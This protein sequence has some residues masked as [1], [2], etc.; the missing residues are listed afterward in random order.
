MA[1]N[2]MDLGSGLLL[3]AIGTGVSLQALDYGLGSLRNIG[4]G[5]FPMAAGVAL[6]VLGLALAATSLRQTPEPDC[7]PTRKRWLPALC[8]IG[9]LLAWAWLTPRLGLVPGTTAL[10]LIACF[11]A[12][13]PR[14]AMVLGLVAI[15]CLM[16]IVL[17]IQALGLPLPIVVF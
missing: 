17:F 14:P 16:G 12:G 3:A 15:L 8:V 10:V 5:V 9:A 1:I 7:T 2:R 13:R 6:A 4:S 11:A